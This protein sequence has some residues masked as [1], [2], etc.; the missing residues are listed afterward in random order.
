[1]QI[2]SEVSVQSC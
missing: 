2:R 1:M